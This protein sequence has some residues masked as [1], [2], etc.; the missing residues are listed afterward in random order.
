[1]ARGR[2]TERGEIEIE[3]ER[4]WSGGEVADLSLADE[5]FH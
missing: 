3:I 5:S 4:D 2:E 1:M